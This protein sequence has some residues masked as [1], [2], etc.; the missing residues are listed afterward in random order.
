M[1]RNAGGAQLFAFYNNGSG[2][3]ELGEGLLINLCAQALDRWQQLAEDNSQRG[4]HLLAGCGAQL[5]EAA[6]FYVDED[7]E[8]AGRLDEAYP[9]GGGAAPLEPGQVR[10]PDSA[11]EWTDWEDPS[12][13]PR[14]P[15]R[16]YQG[17]PQPTEADAAGSGWDIDLEGEVDR[18][19]GAVSLARQIRDLL[20]AILGFDLVDVVVTLITGHW[21]MLLYQ[22]MCVEDLDPGFTRIRENLDRGRFAVQDQW[23]GNAAG[24]AE[25]WLLNYGLAADEL[26]TFGR[27]AGWKMKNFAR[28]AY[29]QFQALNLAI[30]FLI[31]TLLDVALAA[32][33]GMIGGA[34]SVLRGENPIEAVGSVVSAYS[35]VS[36]ILDGLRF[37]GHEF[38]GIAELV[39]G[40]GE[41]VARSWPSNPSEYVHPEFR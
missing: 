15:S 19:T 33:G 12:S 37:L 16:V 10:A 22:A 13:N 17:P 18:V 3:N 41:I 20:R 27:E 32:G 25:V 21:E 24:A 40:N 6:K 26:A 34:I 8:V 36:T 38:V 4:A 35:Q 5:K 2:P 1:T 7:R 11:G 29:H 31:D 28:A 39:A 9:H 30:D 23:E 14:D